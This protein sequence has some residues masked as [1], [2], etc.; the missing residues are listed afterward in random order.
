MKIKYLFY[1][2]Y[3]LILL[4]VPYTLFIGAYS[5]STI[6]I[7]RN[8]KPLISEKIGINDISVVE[9]DIYKTDADVSFLNIK[10]NDLNLESLTTS[11][12]PSINVAEAKYNDKLETRVGKLTAYGHDCL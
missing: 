4:I 9:E 1:A 6:E 5:S 10:K 11:L 12:I 8:I 7:T 3:I 2:I